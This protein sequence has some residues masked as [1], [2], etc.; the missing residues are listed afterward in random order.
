MDDNVYYGRKEGKDRKH[1]AESKLILREIDPRPRCNVHN[2]ERSHDDTVHDVRP[3]AQRIRLLEERE[4]TETHDETSKENEISEKRE[5][6]NTEIT[7]KELEEKHSYGRS[8]DSEQRLGTGTSGVFAYEKKKEGKTAEKDRVVELNGMNRHRV[9]NVERIDRD[10]PENIRR[11]SI[12]LGGKEHADPIERE[13]E[14]CCRQ[15]N[16]EPLEKRGTLRSRREKQHD[17]NTD[18]TSEKTELTVP[19]N[20]N[21]RPIPKVRLITSNDR[22][23]APHEEECQKVPLGIISNTLDT[24]TR[25]SRKTK[26]KL[27]R[28]P[29]AEKQ[30]NQSHPNDHRADLKGFEHRKRGYRV[31]KA[32][33]TFVKLLNC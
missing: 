11:F 21:T 33:G 13:P 29:R 28:R 1:L 8:G 23:N 26:K 12:R 2:S 5:N 27:C 9:S 6:R 4:D 15:K 3:F 24:E 7:A 14:G 22:H 30:E 19:H 31:S 25:G 16:I 18:S 20:E 10:R 17:R 32:H